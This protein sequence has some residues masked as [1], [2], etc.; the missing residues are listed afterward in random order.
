MKIR[1]ND[2]T[3]WTFA[4]DV[5]AGTAVIE[6]KETTGVDQQKV[7]GAIAEIGEALLILSAVIVFWLPILILLWP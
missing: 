6:T 2:I 7:N 4:D 1:T 3:S 5:T